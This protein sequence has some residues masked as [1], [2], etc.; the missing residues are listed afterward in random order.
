MVIEVDARG[1]NCPLP[2]IKTKKAWRDMVEG[3]ITVVIERPEGHQ[4]VVR[5]AESQGCQVTIEENEGLFHIH[6]HKE[7][8]E[9][10][11][12]VAT[13]KSQSVVFI[14][15]DCVLVPVTLGW[16]KYS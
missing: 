7:K 3:D 9:A 15:T 16:A 14:T 4:N 8:V 5:F 6:I 12:P 1:L 2:V 13:E 11:G 10:T